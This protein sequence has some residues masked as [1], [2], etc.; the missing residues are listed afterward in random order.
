LAEKVGMHGK[1]KKFIQ[2]LVIKSHGIRR[3]IQVSMCVE[4][5]KM[6]FPEIGCVC[7]IMGAGLVWLR[8]L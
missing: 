2:H 8:V 5:I 3:N 4:N 1:N 6:D 7:V